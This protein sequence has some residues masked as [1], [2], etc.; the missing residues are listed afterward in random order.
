MLAFQP[1][2]ALID[3]WRQVF[4]LLSRGLDGQL[5]QVSIGELQRVIFIIIGVACERGR[6]LLVLRVEGTVDQVFCT[7]YSWYEKVGLRVGGVGEVCERIACQVQ[8][9]LLILLQCGILTCT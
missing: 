3:P 4:H 8:S 2:Y 9:L 6:L 1:S 7:F 5:G